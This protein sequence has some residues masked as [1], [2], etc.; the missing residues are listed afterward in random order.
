VPPPAAAHRHHYIFIAAAPGAETGMPA[1]ADPSA[2]QQTA[3]HLLCCAAGGRRRACVCHSALVP[4]AD[5]VLSACR[6]TSGWDCSVVLCS[7]G[8]LLRHDR[9]LPAHPAALPPHSFCAL[10]AAACTLRC[11][12]P[13]H[14]PT[15]ATRR[16]PRFHA[17]TSWWRT[18]RLMRGGASARSVR[19]QLLARTTPNT[20]LANTTALPRKTQHY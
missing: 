17:C 10:C 20:T 19:G 18:V 11:A 13:S 15:A 16:L 4:D 2:V 1:P 3:R 7:R 12:P 5:L 14:L 6:C 8:E 9:H